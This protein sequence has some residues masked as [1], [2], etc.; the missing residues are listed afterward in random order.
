MLNPETFQKTAKALTTTLTM[1]IEMT[2]KTDMQVQYR[3][4]VILFRFKATFRQI[5]VL[6]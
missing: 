2:T 4:M 3:T 6:A 1:T 5:M